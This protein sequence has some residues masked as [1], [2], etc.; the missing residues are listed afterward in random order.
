MAVSRRVLS[1]LRKKAAEA[2]R[3]A[4]A[5]PTPAQRANYE[6]K[7]KLWRAAIDTAKKDLLPDNI[8]P[9][10]VSGFLLVTLPISTKID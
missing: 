3:R 9:A 8:K 5:A 6:A 7:E 10:S 4:L 2:S 1:N